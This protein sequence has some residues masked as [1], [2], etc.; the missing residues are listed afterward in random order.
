MENQNALE[1]PKW[2]ATVLDEIDGM[3]A[4]LF[5]PP[6]EL[7]PG[8]QIVGD[9]TPYM[10]KVWAL[11]RLTG[12]DMEQLVL[13][14]KY[15][16]ASE[17]CALHNARIDELRHKHDLLLALFW[18]LSNEHCKTWGDTRCNGVRKDWKLVMSKQEPR[19]PDFIR[20]MLE[21]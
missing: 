6:H 12:R 13:E 2:F 1:K 5:A 11:T 7:E 16:S 18:A 21:S 20:K 3:D 4:S 17:G 14:Q 9:C 19:L 10:Q 8:D 15:H